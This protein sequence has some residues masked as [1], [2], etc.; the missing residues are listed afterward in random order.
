MGAVIKT[1]LER[2]NSKG[3]I[4]KKQTLFQANK[5]PILLLKRLMEYYH[6]KTNKELNHELSKP[7]KPRAC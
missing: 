5:Q 1:L 6:K 3:S 4:A 2:P 7:S